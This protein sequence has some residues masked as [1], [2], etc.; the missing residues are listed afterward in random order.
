MVV[1]LLVLE[2]CKRSD[3]SR[4]RPHSRGVRG[5][6]PQAIKNPWQMQLWVNNF[7]QEDQAPW[8]PHHLRKL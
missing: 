5:R 4:A 2:V 7:V 1:S 3:V 6:T 8:H